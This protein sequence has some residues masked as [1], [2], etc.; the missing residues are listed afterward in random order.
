MIYSLTFLKL[1][2]GHFV[3]F[4]QLSLFFLEDFKGLSIQEL[5]IFFLVCSQMHSHGINHIKKFCNAVIFIGLLRIGIRSENMFH[6]VLSA[7]LLD[8]VPNTHV[9]SANFHIQ[10][11]TLPI[12]DLSKDKWVILLLDLFQKSAFSLPLLSQV[13]VNGSFDFRLTGHA[14]CFQHDIVLN[15]FKYLHIDLA[16]K[17]GSLHP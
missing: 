2:F 13:L 15:V 12:F 4:D 9:W 8:E 10:E 11:F 1:L 14:E 16:K 3:S 17:I 7:I 5:P 6:F